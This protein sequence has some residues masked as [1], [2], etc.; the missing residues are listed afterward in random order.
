MA[1]FWKSAKGVLGTVAPLLA[2][3]LG[4]PLAGQAVAAIGSALGLGPDTDEQQIAQAVARAT[5][6]Q[7]LA[8]READQQFK[9]EMEKLGVELEKIASEDRDSA[10]QREV[11]VKDWTP[12]ILGI[13]AVFSFLAYAAWVTYLD[14]SVGTINLVIGWLG[15]IAT[16]VMTYYFGS[17]AGSA[18]KTDQMDALI[19]QQQRR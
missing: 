18:R 15:G 13:L 19:Q 17:S 6:E 4:G 1:D 3:A 12:R 7:L 5:P 8:L 11:A 10:R 2:T 14:P 16:S 9:I